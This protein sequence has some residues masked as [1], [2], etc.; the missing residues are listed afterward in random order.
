[1]IRGVVFWFHVLAVIS[2]NR[3]YIHIFYKHSCN[4]ADQL[5]IYT[6]LADRKSQGMADL[7]FRS[8]TPLSEL[9]TTVTCK[10]GLKV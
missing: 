7:L 3:D 2:R 10:D 8:Q 5:F 1:M 6:L 9:S 4:T